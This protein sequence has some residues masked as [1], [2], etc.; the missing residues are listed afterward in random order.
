[1]VSGFPMESKP[2]LT[3]TNRVPPVTTGPL[4][5]TLL[6]LA[7]P[8]LGEQILNTFVGL[9]DTWLAGRISLTATSAVGLAAYVGWLASM[10]AMLVATGTTALVARHTGRGDAR[11]TNHYANQSM[12]LAAILGVLLFVG[13]RGLAPIVAQMTNMTGE[14]LGLTVDYL[15]IDAFGHIFMS[16]TI[17][18]CAA[19]RGVGDMRTPLVIFAIINA[20]NILVSSTLVYGFDLG[21]HGIVGGTVAART[22]GGFITVG[23]LIRGRAGLIL[24]RSE[25]RIAWDRTWRVLRIGIP[26]AADGAIMWAGHFTFLAVVSRVAEGSAGQACLAAHIIAV[27]LESLTYLPATAWGTATATMVGQSLGA[28]KPQRAKQAGHEGV[29]QCAA[30]SVGIAVLFFAGASWLDEQMSLDPDVRAVGAGPF[31]IVALL[32]PAMAISIVYI[33]AL[34]GAGD[35]RWPMLITIFGVMIRLSCG[36]YF[37]IVLN[38]G[39]AGAWIGMYGDMLWRAAA[40]AIRYARG[41]WMKTAV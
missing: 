6:T 14:G 32:Q 15:R 9:F 26:A 36:Y 12:T 29:L 35:T 21:V 33:W 17:V 34:R 10:I 41:A 8:I 27:R 38:G 31:R 25:M 40:A 22:L 1:M 11:E 39:L 7:L 13:L 37:G 20:I 18:G 16:L 30:L 19:L 4:R 2:S 3:K 28:E 23:I 24:R 5:R